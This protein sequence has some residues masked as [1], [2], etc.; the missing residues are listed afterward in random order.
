[1]LGA[2]RYYR[3]RSAG[4]TAG[5]YLGRE[6]RTLLIDKEGFGGNVKNVEWIENYPGFSTGVS[7]AQLSSEIMNQA[8]KYGLQMEMAEV[9]E[10]E[11]YSG[12]RCVQLTDGRSFTTET[13]IIACGCK[14]RKLRVPGEYELEGKGIIECALCDGDQFQ[15]KSVVVCGGGDT[16]ITEAMY[17]TKIAAEVLLLEAEPNLTASLSFEERANQ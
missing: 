13:L 12:S 3:W 6:I 10:I 9:G 7:G 2:Y 1:M 14:R 5:I 4:L 11:L 8:T 15:D 17:L 16:G